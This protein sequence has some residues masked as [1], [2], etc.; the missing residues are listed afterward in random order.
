LAEVRREVEGLIARLMG[1]R[2]RKGR[3][4]LEAS[5]ALAKTVMLR[6]GVL[7]LEGVLAGEDGSSL[8]RSCRCGGQFQD[9]KRVGKTVLTVVGPLRLLRTVQ[10]CSRCGSWRVAEDQV[11]DVE[12]TSFSPGVR[13]ML[14]ETGAEVCFAKAKRMIARLAGLDVTAKEVERVAEAVGAEIVGWEAGT[15]AAALESP[16]VL[17]LT[18][19]GTGIPVL[20]RETAGRKGKAADGIARTREAKLGAVFTQTTTDAE[21]NPVRDSASTSY[22]GKIEAVEN[23]GPRLY[24]EAVRRGVERAK[25]VVFIGDGATWLWNLAEEQFPGAVQIVDYYHAA[26]HLGALAQLLYPEDE[27][28]RR[29]WRKPLEKLL[30]AGKIE[31]LV[32]QLREVRVRGRKREAMEKGISYLEKNQGRMRYGAFRRQGWFIGSGVVEAGCRSLIGGRLKQS[33]MHWTVGGANAVLAL[34]CC[35][36]SGRFEDYWESRRVE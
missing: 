32:G 7:V 1:E 31:E 34:R 10:R 5:E 33:G 21:G 13:R 30:W 3:L 14:A 15:S 25:Q 16:A 12:K 4:D 20:K 22:L 11:L 18:A 29:R 19:D 27:M 23:F 26:E 36:E 35:L 6:C 28:G 2:E 24:A 17:Y 8:G 9:R